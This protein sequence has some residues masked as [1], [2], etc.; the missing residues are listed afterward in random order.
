VWKIRSL[1]STTNQVQEEVLRLGEEEEEEDPRKLRIM[2]QRTHTSTTN[3]MEEAVAP[4][5]AQKPKRTYL[6]F[7]S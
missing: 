4:K 3:I 5:R 1:T 6:E 7:N 2:T